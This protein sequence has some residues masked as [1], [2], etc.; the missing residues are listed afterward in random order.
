MTWRQ[1]RAANMRRDYLR[2]WDK[3]H[4][5]YNS[6]E[7]LKAGKVQRFAGHLGVIES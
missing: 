2:L 7:L 4:P 5:G 3:H 6:P 1:M